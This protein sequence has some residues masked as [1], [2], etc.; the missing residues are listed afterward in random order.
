MF[1]PLPR[2]LNP[3]ALWHSA[4]FGL[5]LLGAAATL[6]SS[7]GAALLLAML[8]AAGSYACLRMAQTNRPDTK[9]RLVFGNAI[10]ALGLLCFLMLLFT[11]DLMLALMALLVASQL[12]L[13]L[14]SETA[15]AASKRH[16]VGLASGFAALM[17]GAAESTSA[18]YLMLMLAYSACVCLLLPA[19]WRELNTEQ[20]AE[21]KHPDSA[22]TP[23][24]V[25]GMAPW[26]PTAA[27][28]GLALLAYLLLPMPPQA[29]IGGTVMPLSQTSSISNPL[30]DAEAERSQQQPADSDSDTGKTE[31]SQ[32]EQSSL[33]PKA[34]WES[35]Q[36]PANQQ[37]YDYPG[38]R[39]QF[40]I[41]DAVDSRDPATTSGLD[42][43]A[44]VLLM[45][46]SYASHADHPQP[47]NHYVK[48]RNFNHFDGRQWRTEQD[49]LQKWLPNG[50]GQFE[51]P[52]EHGQQSDQ[53]LLYQEFTVKHP[54]GAWLPAVD[55]PVRVAI[56]ASSI[57]SD[58]WHHPVTAEPLPADTRYT[59]VSEPQHIH[60]RSI[61]RLP[62]PDANDLQLPAKMDPRISKLASNITQAGRTPLQRAEQLESYLRENYQFSLQSVID[63]QG[64]TP[65]APFLFD[66]KSGHCEHFASSMVVM[67][68]SLGIPARLATGFSASQR[69]PVTGYFELRAIDGHAWAE[70]WIEG[71]WL[72]FEP[73]PAYPRPTTADEGWFNSTADQLNR[74]IQH[75]SQQSE[76]ESAQT[77]S[78][79]DTLV[80]LLGQLGRW[81]W[82]ALYWLLLAPVGFVV[83][84]FL[85]LLTNAWPL[86]FVFAI[87]AT[88]G[89][90]YRERWLATSLQRWIQYRLQKRKYHN[91]QE[92]LDY[93]HRWIDRMATL[94]GLQ[95]NTGEPI[96]HW[97]ARM[98]SY[99]AALTGAAPT[100]TASTDATTPKGDT[101]TAALDQFC[102]WLQQRWYGQEDIE[103]PE[104]DL[105]S[106]ALDVVDWLASL[107]INT[108]AG[109]R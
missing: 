108:T 45:K 82:S 96:E 2:S 42:L 47:R 54:V 70:A 21:T 39:Q 16:Y 46:T 26:L 89:W 35:D 56:A 4:Q 84:R 27:V 37:A 76:L 7:T 104:E 52:V 31:Q 43:D 93:C 51:L 106:I 64:N 36:I 30:W 83:G 94:Q 107:P 98:T 102:A 60:G 34:L 8:A 49:H 1:K 58:R 18:S 22:K 99:A 62:A 63:N 91:W 65:L 3:F 19:L 6:F 95:R 75:R 72:S 109:L 5:G 28:V 100:G 12:A 67:L 97:Q 20:S 101:S 13:N 15:Q 50:D 38:F 40:S 68:R 69:N 103:Q 14:T 32:D 80:N 78:I 41:E 66:R 33:A 11:T 86:L 74:Y 81:I 9:Q 92:D 53:G 57:A 48:V 29:N 71:K 88:A 24:H 10:A 85:W 79:T 87:A 77:H 61:S 25:G 73:T 90:Y 44:V 59:V 23:G 55:T 17:I 105:P